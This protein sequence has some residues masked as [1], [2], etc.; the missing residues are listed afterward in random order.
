MSLI[1]LSDQH[2]RRR[3]VDISNTSEAQAVLR[4]KKRTPEYQVECEESEQ[5]VCPNR[6]VAES[7]LTPIW[8]SQQ[9]CLQKFLL[10]WIHRWFFLFHLVRL[11]LCGFLVTILLGISLWECFVERGPIGTKGTTLAEDDGEIDCEC[12]Q[13][14]WNPEVAWNL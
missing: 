5:Y 14:D 11:L 12:C 1:R 9:Q 6:Y 4:V 3:G 8:D 7:R 13:N 10:V 2:L